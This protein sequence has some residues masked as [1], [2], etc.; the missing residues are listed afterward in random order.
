MSKSDSKHRDSQSAGPVA[1]KPTETR[2]DA[3]HPV[4]EKGLVRKKGGRPTPT[5]K[6]AAK[7]LHAKN[8][9]RD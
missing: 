9:G 3:P 5:K 6:P 1:K 8:F 4:V 2:I 7:E